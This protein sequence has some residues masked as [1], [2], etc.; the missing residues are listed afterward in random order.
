MIMMDV[1]ASVSIKGRSS[2][3]PYSFHLHMLVIGDGRTH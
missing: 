3:L 1:A 2:R